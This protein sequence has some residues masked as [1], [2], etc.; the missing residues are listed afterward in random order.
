MNQFIWVEWAGLTPHQM[1]VDS[2]RVDPAWKEGVL[3]VMAG[4]A[5]EQQ[6]QMDSEGD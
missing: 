4:Y 6:K 5:A 3:Q 1:G 2:S